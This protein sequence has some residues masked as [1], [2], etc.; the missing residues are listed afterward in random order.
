MPIDDP[1]FDKAEPR[2]GPLISDTS[3]RWLCGTVL[4][5]VV[6]VGGGVLFHLHTEDVMRAIGFGGVLSICAWI[7]WT[8]SR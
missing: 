8:L 2:R 7:L 5:V 6:L 4:G 1:Y 3:V